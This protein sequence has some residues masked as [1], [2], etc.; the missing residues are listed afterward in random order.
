[1]E[2]RGQRLMIYLLLEIHWEVQG[3][4]VKGLGFGGSEPANSSA[5][6]EF[7]FPPPTSTTLTEGSIFLS[8]GTTLK[9][10]GK[11]AGIPAATW[12]SG[13]A[14]NTQ[15]DTELVEQDLK[16]TLYVLVE[17]GLPP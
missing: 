16:Q 11:A 17:E 13:G 5:T 6:E 10:F 15:V 9:G 14:L 3:S 12:A 7:S 2:L 1:M 8:G 4:I